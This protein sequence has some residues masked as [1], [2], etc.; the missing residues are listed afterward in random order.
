M[1]YTVLLPRKEHKLQ[2]IVYSFVEVA[3]I[4]E[5]DIRNIFSNDIELDYTRTYR[6]YTY[7]YMKSYVHSSNNNLTQTQHNPN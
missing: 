1:Q 4:K 3:S 2:T 5:L 6:I 7:V